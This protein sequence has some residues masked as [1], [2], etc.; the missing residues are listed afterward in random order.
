MCPGLEE[1]L[2][3]L[4]GLVL[5][6]AGRPLIDVALSVSVGIVEREL[7]PDSIGMESTL[8]AGGGRKQVCLL[9][10]SDRL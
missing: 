6:E 5:L 9:G 3:C 7:S 1:Q 10:D 8:N 2:P 4:S